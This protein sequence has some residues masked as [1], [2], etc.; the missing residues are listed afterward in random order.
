MQACQTLILDQLVEGQALDECFKPGSALLLAGKAQV[1][2][3]VKVCE[4]RTGPDLEA[5][6]DALNELARQN[7]LDAC[8]VPSEKEPVDVSEH[9]LL[10]FLEQTRIL[11]EFGRE[12]PEP[13]D[14]QHVLLV[15][16]LPL[17][18]RFLHTLSL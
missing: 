3:L 18:L 5:T 11:L 6:S 16:S 12:V 8:G 10:D 15:I 1:F 14:A 9:G 4:T 2:E 17:P 7:R 13:V